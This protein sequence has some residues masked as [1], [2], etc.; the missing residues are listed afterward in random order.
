[1]RLGCVIFLLFLCTSGCI[2]K[3]LLR[4]HNI[5]NYRRSITFQ[6]A[7]GG[8]D[9]DTTAE[10]TMPEVCGQ[11]GFRCLDDRSFQVCRYTDIDG[12]T[13]EPQEPHQCADDMICDEDNIAYCTPKFKLGDA[14]PG[15]GTIDRRPCNGLRDTNQVR[16]RTARNSS[17]A[18]ECHEFGLFPGN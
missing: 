16:L 4:N 2:T 12:H 7:G 14:M 17:I 13:E 8:G 1:M 15:K 9:D 11:Y 10:P 6:G 18:F 5:R 3:S